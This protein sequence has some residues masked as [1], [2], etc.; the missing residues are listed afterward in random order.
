MP[1]VEPFVASPAPTNELTSLLD[2][3]PAV[4]INVIPPVPPPPI[5]SSKLG[6]PSSLVPGRDGAEL[7]AIVEIGGDEG[8]TGGDERGV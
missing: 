4:V 6:I 3:P 5:R 7:P 8:G 2:A 1:V